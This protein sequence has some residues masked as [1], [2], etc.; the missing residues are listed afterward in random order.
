M[1]RNVVSP[2]LML[3][4]VLKGGIFHKNSVIGVTNQRL[5]ISHSIAHYY[6]AALELS[7]VSS[8][9]FCK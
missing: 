8:S 1:W 6:M 5:F 7:V 2:A 4:P 3:K 9:A